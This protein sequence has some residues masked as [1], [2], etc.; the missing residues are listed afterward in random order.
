MTLFLPCSTPSSGLDLLW[1]VSFTE[2]RR[3][4][5]PGTSGKQKQMSGHRSSTEKTVTA[6]EGDGIRDAE[7]LGRMGS[8]SSSGDIQCT[9]VALGA[10]SLWR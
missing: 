10:R 7:G 8:M 3:H 2:W 5:R 9:Q 6:V 4:P 1:L